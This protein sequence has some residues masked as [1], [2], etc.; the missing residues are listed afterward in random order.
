[1]LRVL[2]VLDHSWPILDGYCQRSRNIVR[3][4]RELGIESVVLTGPAQEFDDPEAQDVDL[5]EIHYHRTPIG[6]GFAGQAIRNRRPLLREY[7]AV[8]LLR[9]RIRSL[10]DDSKFDLVH[11]HTPALCGLAGVLATSSRRMPLVYEIRSFWED[12][13]VA[14]TKSTHRS[15]RYRLGRALETYVAKRA[16]AVVGISQAILK[17]IAARGISTS[18]LFYV[19]NGVDAARFVPRAKDAAL[20]AELGVNDVPILG[21]LGTLFPWEGIPWLVRAA[22]QLYRNGA[23]FKLLLVGDGMAADEVRRAIYDCSASSYVLFIGRVPNDQVERYY[24]VMDVLV[25]PRRS[26]RVAEMVTPLKPLEAMALGKAVLGSSVGGLRELIDEYRTGVL[27]QTEDTDDFC[28][29]A[30]LLLAD[31]ELRHRLGQAAREV[32]TR[33]KDWVVLGRRYE[34]LYESV[35]RR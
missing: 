14:Q 19:P 29:K 30:S 4:Q 13:A 9:D 24:S 26:A 16:A 17:D 10:L 18:K 3:A 25:Y 20:A 11:A 32:V 5:D 1:M 6:G 34:S 15:A 27:F 8:R 21:Y 33:E 23:R 7:L 2:H 12:S 22:S 35:L 28:K 31:A